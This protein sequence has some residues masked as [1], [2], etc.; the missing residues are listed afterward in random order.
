[1]ITK[2]RLVLS[3]ILAGAL[4][5]FVWGFTLVRPTDT[6][7]IFKNSAVVTVSPAPASL[8]LRQTSVAIT[9]A[10]GFTLATANDDGLAIS[11]DGATTGIP[12]DEIQILPGQNEY[13]F[14]PGAGQQV[15]ELP[16]GRVCAVAQIERASQPNVPPTPFSWC[17]QTQ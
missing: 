14:L 7:V 16:V 10:P 8:V 1:M 9:L 11:S 12:L 6:P 17:F 3:V 13:T 2:R 5:L 15:S 4:V